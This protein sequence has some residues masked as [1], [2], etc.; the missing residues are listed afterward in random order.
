MPT[1]V[2]PW[3]PNAQA[4]LLPKA[5]ATQERTLAAV[6]CSAMFGPDTPRC[7]SPSHRRLHTNDQLMS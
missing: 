3:K 1:F 7:D 4:H 6:R 5:G 2:F